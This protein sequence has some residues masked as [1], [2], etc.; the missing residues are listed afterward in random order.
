MIAAALKE[1]QMAKFEEPLSVKNLERSCDL[2]SGFIMKDTSKK[3]PSV[4]RKFFL[5]LSGLLKFL[6]RVSQA[7][8]LDVCKW[9]RGHEE[10]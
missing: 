7:R 9:G 4:Q 6:Y 10:P 8:I 3:C 1:S 5:L 2:F